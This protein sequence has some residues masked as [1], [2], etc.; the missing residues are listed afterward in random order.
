ML[1]C[2]V[3][4]VN[5]IQWLIWLLRV[6]KYEEYLLVKPFLKDPMHCS[7]AHRFPNRIAECVSF[8]SCLNH[9]VK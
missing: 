6:E 7:E 2:Y 9:R 3:E 4:N 8:T 5:E 1:A